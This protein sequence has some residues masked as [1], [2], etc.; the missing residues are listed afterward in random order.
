M[1]PRV[2]PTMPTFQERVG[3][4]SFPMVA[5]ARRLKLS[6]EIFPESE[7]KLGLSIAMADQP[8]PISLERSFIAMKLRP[9]S[10]SS[11][12]IG[13]APV[14]SNSERFHESAE[15][16]IQVLGAGKENDASNS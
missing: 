12:G 4:T 13:I 2:M 6:A 14:R 1:S 5:I 3:L 11:F 15:E 10:S 7:A 9:I 8:G 16:N